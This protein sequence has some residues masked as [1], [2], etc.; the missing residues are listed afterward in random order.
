MKRII[1][2][3]VF[4]NICLGTYAFDRSLNGS[5][6]LIMNGQKEEFVRFNNNEIL[7]MNILFRSSDY[8]E[9][10]DSIY[11]ANF[12]GDSVL[13]QYYRLASNK[14]LFIL[15]NTDDPTQSVTLILSKL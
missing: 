2:V 8:T 9:A 5:W 12:E 6:G 4:A 14:L 15:W 11:I 7:I 10:D 3:I 13:I 1:C